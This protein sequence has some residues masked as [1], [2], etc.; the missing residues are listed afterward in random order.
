[1]VSRTSTTS[2]GRH[3][4]RPPRPRIVALACLL[5][6]LGLGAPA[7]ILAAL[8][9]LA[10][11]SANAFFQPRTSIDPPWPA[12]TSPAAGPEGSPSAR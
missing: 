7:A 2:T 6:T 8:V 12:R 11:P 1:M 9:L 4:A 10:L 5:L 3:P